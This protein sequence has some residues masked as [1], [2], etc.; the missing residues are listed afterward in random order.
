MSKVLVTGADGF[1][2]S[3]LVEKLVQK[4]DS[5]KALCMYNS[6]G[7]WGWLDSIDINIRN[8]IEVVLG[9]IRDP[10]C[11]KKIM[12][13]CE[14]VYHLAALIAIPYSYESPASYVDTN[15]HGT[16][17]IVEAGKEIGV[18]RIVHTSTSET[19]GTA[20]FVPI[21]ED[22]PLVGQSPYA[23]SK[24]GADQIALSYYRSFQ[25]PISV[26]R[27][28]NA[29]GPRQSTRAVIPTII[30]QIASGNRKIKLGA[31]SPTRDFNYVSDI[32]DAFIAVAESNSVLGKVINAASNFEISIGETAYL[33]ANV[34]NENIEIITEEKRLRPESSEVNRL[35]GENKLLNQL[36]NWEPK[37]G[38]KEGFKK[39][40]IKTCDW[41]SNEDN[42]KK[43]RIG[44]YTI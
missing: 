3:H 22:H 23:A 9:D 12:T 39:G 15:I 40:L 5:V 31:V 34:M 18:S 27:P 7:S 10:F 42:L 26:L 29:Y 36:T 33:I 21:T 6:F 44:E 28:F 19:Y 43:Y 17:N 11:V 20:Q 37:Y 1:I 32:C 8:N 30:T 38:G 4:G 14:K 35:Y 13:G 2:G 41:F 25:T 16:L 24:I